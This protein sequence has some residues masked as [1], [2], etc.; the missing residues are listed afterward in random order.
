VWLRRILPLLICLLLFAPSALAGT[1]FYVDCTVTGGTDGAG[2]YADPYESFADIAQ[3]SF[4]TGDDIYFLE[5]STC[6]A[7][8]GDGKRLDVTWDGT[9]GDHVVIGCYDGDG[10]FDCDADRPILD[11]LN[12]YPTDS[13]SETGLIEKY[14]VGHDYLDITYLKIVNPGSRGIAISGTN[15]VT[16]DN[17]HIFS[18]MQIKHDSNAAG[19]LIGKV[20]DFSITNSYIK[21]F[22]FKTLT[23]SWNRVGIVISPAGGPG[24]FDETY[25]GTVSGNVLENCR[26]CIDVISH[27]RNITVEKNTIY[28][29][30]NVALFI[31]NA[32]S[33]VFRHNLI[34]ND[35]SHAGAAVGLFV[36]TEEWQPDCYT[37]GNKVY[38]N[39][40]AGL[41]NAIGFS[42]LRDCTGQHP[43]NNLFYN[44]TFVDNGTS[45]GSDSINFSGVDTIE[46][47]GNEFKNNI[48]YKPTSSI[49]DHVSSCS[50][51]TGYISFDANIF[52]GGN[53][54][55]PG[56]GDCLNGLIITDPKIYKTSGWRLLS[57]GTLTGQEFRITPGSSA[58]NTGVQVD[59]SSDDCVAD[60]TAACLM[61]LN[62]V[63]FTA[64]PPPT[65]TTLYDNND[66]ATQ[67][68][69][70]DVSL[71]TP[72]K[73]SITDPTPSETG[74]PLDREVDSS[75]FADQSG[76]TTSHV[77]SDWEID[78]TNQFLSP[79]KYTYDDATNKITWTPTLP[80]NGLLY[81]R[82]R[83][84]NSNGDS[85]WSDA[86]YFETVGSPP[87]G[88][89]IALR[90]AVTGFTG[91]WLLID[92]GGDEGTGV[93]W[94]AAA[95]GG[96]LYNSTILNCGTAGFD[97]DESLTAKNI[98]LHNNAGPDI[99][100]AT[101]KT[102]TASN[103]SIQDSAKSGDGTYDSGTSDFSK[104]ELFYDFS[105]GDFRLRRSS[106][107]VD[108]GT[109]AIY[110][111]IEVDLL[112]YAATD[113][114]GD[115]TSG[116]EI[117]IGGYETPP[118]TG[119][120][121]GRLGIGLGMGLN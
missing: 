63:D 43:S 92:C 25:N 80:E 34:Y 11:G 15:N 109:S 118:V 51:S 103:N 99:D 60:F 105:G 91:K 72:D 33:N 9:S 93:K 57:V 49:G 18:G 62:G 17:L 82:V 27:A 77:S 61:N 39:L 110:S 115:P 113:G 56:S 78:T 73:P 3:D 94:V 24:E 97:V 23:G 95:T 119:S 101:G 52:F 19:I 102:V 86:V 68:I 41:S 44:N 21:D 22:D 16:I 28:N 40:V 66:Y 42:I 29:A 50:P 13:Q 32:S 47:T 6:T 45:G 59:T 31:D 58:E 65:G 75:A 38:G 121:R 81:I 107:G 87:A 76:C 10:D 83:H 98:L 5:G 74:V 30:Q 55:L 14:D 79:D 108:K 36:H 1:A 88:G 116:A 96:T 37:N 112:S 46:G 26:E 70:A 100:I 120:G 2:T 106:Y 53:A 111:G 12:T 84:T 71:C 20:V 35:T 90:V 64:G 67:E 7:S 69:G 48:S 85:E 54:A 114:S 117:E 8:S 89:D 104:S 4:S